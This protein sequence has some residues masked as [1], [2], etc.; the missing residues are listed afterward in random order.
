[1]VVT[2][3]PTSG[4]TVTVTWQ[5]PADDGGNPIIGYSV[6]CVSSP[7]GVKV[8]PERFLG[9]ATTGTGP[10][11][12]TGLS[13]LTTYKCSVVAFNN[14]GP[15]APAVS[16][17]FTTPLGATPPAAP[18]TPTFVEDPNDGTKATISW[19]APTSDGGSPITAYDV[20]CTSV[21]G[22]AVVGPLTFPAPSTGPVALTGLTTYTTYQCTVTATNSAGTGAPSAPST[23]RTTTPGWLYVPAAA[24]GVNPS[25]IYK[26]PWP[27]TAI[28]FDATTT[29]FP[30]TDANM[31]YPTQAA[32]SG[33][34]AFIA[35]D[36][37]GSYGAPCMLGCALQANGDI[38]G[39]TL[40]AN[41]GPLSGVTAVGSTVY[42]VT[43][44][45][46]VG[47]CTA[48]PATHLLSCVNTALAQFF[49]TPSPE[50]AAVRGSHMYVTEPSRGVL[51][52]IVGAGSVITSCT[53]VTPSGDLHGTT[54][55]VLW[56]N[57]ALLTEAISNDVTML[58]TTT[59][60]YWT[61]V[62]T[63][64]PI[65]GWSPYGVALINDDLYIAGDDG[66]VRKTALLSS[67]PYF[68]DDPPVTIASNFN[69]GS[70]DVL[71]LTFN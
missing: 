70:R 49:S 14:A 7:G 12:F 16:A 63:L 15:S 71:S 40:T 32:F 23:A 66:T 51:D 35:I 9:A 55:I 2:T 25:R 27:P 64:T 39:C 17:E 41:G 42:Q 61:R 21:P 60:P 54:G 5:P 50:N 34:S 43:T 69:S 59:T 3:S 62:A 22:G 19:T 30:Q 33:D 13:P 4:T 20:T 56:G 67:S 68:V 45:N 1:V 52:C 53:Q 58:D 44:Y 8:G 46:Y 11:G 6:T 24:A 10:G 38:T 47:V 28:P 31:H 26:C 37:S 57:F 18:G 65:S 36:C 29:C 48:D